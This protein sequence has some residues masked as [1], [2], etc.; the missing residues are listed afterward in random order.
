[1]AVGLIRLY[2]ATGKQEYL[3]MAGLAASW[4]LGNNAAGQPMYDPSTG[5]CYDG[6]R[7]ST[8][9][10]KNSG[11]ESTIEALGTLQEVEHYDLARSFIHARRVRISVSR[12]VLAAL[13]AVPG[14][15]ETVVSVELKS[16]SLQVIRGS[17]GKAYMDRLVATNR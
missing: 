7:D 5:R 16:K 8:T 12:D 13:F 1:M 4:L 14:G 3:V 11:A 15:E 9:I 2:E 6:I 17:E 10:N